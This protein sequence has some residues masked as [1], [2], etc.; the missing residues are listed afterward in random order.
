MSKQLNE[1]KRFQKIAGIL[2]EDISASP[3]DTLIDSFLAKFNLSLSP[4]ERARFAKAIEMDY[5]DG[6]I[7]KA[8]VNDAA[9]IFDASGIQSIEDSDDEPGPRF[10]DIPYD[11][12]DDYAG[13]G[14]W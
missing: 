12:T 7:S 9:E 11:P 4:K 2:K 10:D 13:R 5:E 8:T 6:D 14:D 3:V 1:V